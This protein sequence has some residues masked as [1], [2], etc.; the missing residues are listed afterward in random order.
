MAGR[1]EPARRA[2]WQR[3][4]PNQLPEA[5]R[6]PRLIVCARPPTRRGLVPRAQPADPTAAAVCAPSR[7]A[8]GRAVA[9]VVP[10]VRVDGPVASAD[11]AAHGPVVDP[12]DGP[13]ALVGARVVA[14]VAGDPAAGRVVVARAGG[15]AAGRVA[16]ARTTPR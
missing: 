4:P 6:P 5:R 10:V 12:A 8:C 1:R 9:L 11:P 16:V 13:A 3:N 15:P 14:L 7:L 2:Q